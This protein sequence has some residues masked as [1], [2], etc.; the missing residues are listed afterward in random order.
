MIANFAANPTHHFKAVGLLGIEGITPEN[1]RELATRAG[2][3]LINLVREWH[4][5]VSIESGGN[6]DLSGSCYLTLSYNSKGEYQLHQ[7]GIDLPDPSKLK[8]YW[9]D[10]VLRGRTPRPGNSIRGDDKEGTVLE[11][12]GE[13]GGQL[14]Y[15][16]KTV[17]A[18][19]QSDTFKLEPLPPGTPHGLISRAEVYYPDL[20]PK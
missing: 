14:K 15:Y 16:P 6:V 18:L 2:K 19:W 1:Y 12:F 5:A 11:W 4:I 17:D 20:W 7:F 8:W 3:S 13:S 10:I 9:P